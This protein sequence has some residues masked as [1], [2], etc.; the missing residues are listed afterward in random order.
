MDRCWQLV[1]FRAALITH[2]LDRRLIERT[3]EL[4]GRDGGFC[5]R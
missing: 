2:D 4:A 3:V 5:P 1:R